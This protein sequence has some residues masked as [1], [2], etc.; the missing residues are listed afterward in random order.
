MANQQPHLSIDLWLD[1]LDM[2]VYKPIFKQYN[3]VENILWM[4]ERDLKNLGIKNGSHRARLGSSLAILKEKYDR[5]S[6]EN[7]NMLSPNNQSPHSEKAKSIASVSPMRQIHFEESGVRSWPSTRPSTSHSTKHSSPRSSIENFVGTE[8]T[9]EELKRALEKEL[10]LD[11]SDLR[12]YAWYHGT[13]L[14]QRAEELVVQDGDFLVRDC[15]SQPGDYVITCKWKNVPLHF[16]I[17]KVILNP[18]TVYERFQYCFEKESFDSISDFITYYV[19]SKCPLSEASGVIISHPVNRVMPLSYYA[20]RYGIQCQIHYVAKAL[21]NIPSSPDHQNNN[22]IPKVSLV[23]ISP[24]NISRSNYLQQ[25]EEDKLTVSNNQSSETNKMKHALHQNSNL[26]R[27][28]SDPML[29]PNTERRSLKRRPNS[30]LFSSET[31][32]A[33]V[34]TT[35]DKPPPKPSR[36]PSKKYAQR[37]LVVKKERKLSDF[38]D[39]DSSAPNYI[40]VPSV[41]PTHADFQR[42]ISETR[43]SFLD[44]PSFSSES[45]TPDVESTS[46]YFTMPKISNISTFNPQHFRTS[47]LS[48]ENPP[49]EGVVLSRLRQILLCSAPKTI[50]FHLTRMDLEVAKHFEGIDLGLGVSS[51]LELILLPQGEQ[52]QKDLIERTECM[53]LFV[54]VLILTSPDED[55]RM[56]ILNRWIE[57]AIETKTTLGNYYGFTSIMLGLTLPEILGLQSTWL[58]LR[59]SHTEIAFMFETK[60]R[61]TLKALQNGSGLEAP[62]TCLPYILSLILILQKHISVMSS[63]EKDVDSVCNDIVNFALP[64]NNSAGDFG[65]QLLADHLENGRNILQQVPVFKKNGEMSLR[66]IKFQDVI[67]DVFNTEFH[68]RLL[69]GYRG[70]VVGSE[71]RHTIFQKVVNSLYNRCIATEN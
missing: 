47:L 59:H 50:A 16:I 12:S 15:I 69:W 63:V 70:S 27:M 51:G 8:A 10:N 26:I 55:E 2:N 43:F 14:R 22:S 49:L 31:L 29:S 7:R 3:G 37:P 6:K 9:A 21:E 18:D 36:V 19:G 71:Q 64:G 20:S 32:S 40:P 56:K 52:M 42:Q 65:L 11:S 53:K 4:T 1:K 66:S 48:S 39:N 33:V 54:A 41:S 30:G 46:K 62:N 23:E 45:S 67:L 25:S 61:P 38:D 44:R 68:L 13:I 35:E 34:M 24:A 17:K 57:I 60:L 58:A 28:G 5:A